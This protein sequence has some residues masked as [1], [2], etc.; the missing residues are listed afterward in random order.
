MCE[1][2]KSITSI[3]DKIYIATMYIPELDCYE[4]IKNVTQKL[5][6]EIKSLLGKE[7]E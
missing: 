2:N 6:K 1:N 7:S 4:H 3:T 5:H